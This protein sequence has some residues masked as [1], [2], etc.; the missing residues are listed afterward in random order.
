MS[1]RA[2]KRIYLDYAST[3]PLDSRVQKVMGAYFSKTF[4]NPSS[5]HAEGV[6]AKKAL[7]GARISVA[8]SLEARS[9]E[10]V[11]TGGGTEAN[12][13]A[14]LG[15][16][17]G[18][19]TSTEEVRPPQ[20][21]HVVTTNIEHASVLEPL[22]E[23]E[24]AGKAEVTYVPVESSGIVRPEKIIA[25]I[26]P[27]TALI[28]VMYAN[29][30]IG[31]IQPIRKIGQMLQSFR[32]TKRSAKRSTLN[33]M[34]NRIPIFHTDA[35]QAPLYLR[36]LVN[37]LGVDLMTL[38]G[39]KMYG[40]KGIGALYVRRGT[41]LTPILLG[42]GQERGMRSTTEN[43]PAVVG[44]AEA[45]RMATSEREKESIRIT[46]LRNHLYSRMFKD[47]KIDF[48]VNGSLKEGER[49]PN[50]LNVSFPGIDTEFLTL[51][52]DASGVAVSTKSSCL[53]GEKESYVVKAL[54]GGTRG[55]G[56][57]LRFTLGRHTT[58]KEIEYTESILLKLLEKGY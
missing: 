22:R 8:R 31:T 54:G 19:L 25:A 11:F 18:G 53:A 37:A 51:Q 13:L 5:I 48:L 1:N 47:M 7:D 49:L 30:E 21:P 10:V 56:A 16:L 4:G 33:I 12:N 23:L 35:C 26:R 9:Q 41:P 2:R 20:K 6:E 14:L 40:P 15:S 3:T 29:N 44:F 45:L 36:C 27:N 28:S 58:K 43:I 24:R 17:C 46:K 39:H 55:A 42:G 38:D 50:N 52:L 34:K 57:T 32:S